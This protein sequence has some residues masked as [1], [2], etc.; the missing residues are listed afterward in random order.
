[1][2][3]PSSVRVAMAA[4][5][6]SVLAA[7]TILPLVQGQGW[8]LDVAL[9]AALTG[10]AGLAVRRVTTAAHVVVGVQVLVWVVAVCMIFLNRTAWLGVL[11]GPDAVES[12]QQLFAQGLRVMHHAAPPVSDTAGVVFVTAG[13]LSLVALGVDVLAVTVRRPAVAGLPLLAVY[14]VPVA[15]LRDGLG[16]PLFL[17]A[18]AGFL[19]LVAVDS[20]DRVQAWGRVLSGSTS[21]RS[22][23]G[24]VFSGAR[25]LAGVSLAL[26]VILPLLVP[27]IGDRVLT[28]SGTGTGPGDGTVTVLN[29]LLRL[30]QDL[31]ARD[32]TPLL[33]YTT[34]MTSPQPL[35]VVVDDEFRGDVWQP[36]AGEVPRD[37]KVQN[38]AP[39]PE[40][41]GP[42][43]PLKQEQTRVTVS[44]LAQ[45]YLPVPFPWRKIDVPGNWIF[46]AK[47]Q[48]VLGEGATSR[49]LQYTVDHYTVQATPDQL[50]AAAEPDAAVL[51]RYTALPG[52][53]PN[54]IRRLATLHGGTTGTAYDK[55]VRLRDWLRTFQYSEQAPGDGTT[56][57]GSS[58]VLAFLTEKRGYCVHFASAMAV[59]ARTLDIP[60][61]VVVGFLP[62]TQR[63]NGTWTVTLR[64]AHAWPEL[65]FQGYG[66]VRFEPT[67]P[68]RTAGVPDLVESNQATAPLP[69]ASASASVPDATPSASANSRLPKEEQVDG[70]AAGD[71]TGV[72][73]WH[74]VVGVLTSPW[75]YAALAVLLALSLPMVVLALARRARWRR[76]GTRAARAEAALDELGER[77]ADVGVPLSA[78]R[79]PRGMR[80]W[81]VGAE[82]V[83]PDRTGPLDRLVAELEAARYAPPGGTGLDAQ[84]LRADVKAVARI[85]AEQ[86]PAG[87]R[88]LARLLPPSGVALLTGAASRADA[89]VEGAGERAAGRVGSVGEEVRKLVG[90]GRRR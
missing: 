9:I 14:C 32:D 38:S 8:F 48:V 68:A 89:A 72:S 63:A 10:G 15:I 36:S 80:E 83:P 11:P 65:Y 58:A 13:G 41:L 2:I 55:A 24:M 85:V 73:P 51:Q 75:T 30:R 16:W 82:H 71:V 5:L 37:N 47:S 3:L 87:R 86:V 66:W 42:D 84:E 60:A 57:S 45:N 33:T 88:R 1:V 27:G 90:P 70:S 18:G 54:E 22:S 43:V 62:G 77:L 34:T 78:A 35:R 20:V 50:R 49:G 64:D 44:S 69:S 39:R 7:V 67:P 4:W 21:S 56:D 29:P 53:L 81:L 23:L 19:L 40:G 59:M 26:A 31:G 6:A 46:D 12:G 52:D 74:R 28:G 17:L 61:R 25:R 79:T 76:A